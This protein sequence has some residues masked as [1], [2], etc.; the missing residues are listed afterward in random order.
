MIAT[1]EV[2][3]RLFGGE[4]SASRTLPRA[5]SLDAEQA[6]IGSLLLSADAIATVRELHLAPEHFADR[7]HQQFLRAV[8]ALDEAGTVVDPLTV[9]DWL[10]TQGESDDIRD[11]ANQLTDSV[12]MASA[13]AHYAKIVLEYAQRRTLQKTADGL[14]TAALDRRIGVTEALDHAEQQLFAARPSQSVG[15]Q[16]VKSL[17]LP[18][19]QLLED[20]TRTPGALTGIPTPFAELDRLT[21]GLHSGQLTILAARPSVGK[22]AVAIQSAITAC[23]A[24]HRVLF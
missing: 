10:V 16:S 24:G 2:T 6:T 1:Y 17:I 22:T 4:V 18:A 7:T 23:K 3:N 19:M 20:R 15:V 5:W 8:Y 21:L 12:A 13:V 14:A 9:A 11:A